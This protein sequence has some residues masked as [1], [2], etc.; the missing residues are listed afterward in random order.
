MTPF[1]LARWEDTVK[2]IMDNG[3][4]HLVIELGELIYLDSSGIGSIIRALRTA[5][6]Y[7]GSLK[8]AAANSAIETI[9]DVTRLR[10]IIDFYPDL[11]S[12]L[13]SFDKK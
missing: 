3:Q 4:Y 11:P 1:K 13:E 12:A 10:E 2:T 7:G 9:F 8:I 6:K 5:T